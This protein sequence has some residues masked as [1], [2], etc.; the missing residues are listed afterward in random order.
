MVQF[1]VESLDWLVIFIYFIEIVDI[2]AVIFTMKAL[3]GIL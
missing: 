1:I 2:F 3:I